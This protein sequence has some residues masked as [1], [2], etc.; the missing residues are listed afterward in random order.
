MFAEF[1]YDDGVM[2]AEQVALSVMAEQ[3]GTPFYCYST[4]RLRKNYRAFAEAF[5][6]QGATICFAVKACPNL[7]IIRTFGAM[8]AGADVVSGGELK[9]ALTAG[10]P[11][12]KI[13]FSGVGKSRADLELAIGARI[14]QINVE[15]VPELEAI[16][17][18]AAAQGVKMPVV[19]RVNPDVDPKTHAKIS[20][21]SK[22]T[23]FGIE[24]EQIPEA[25]AAARKFPNL[26]LTGFAVHIGSQLTELQPFRD[27]FT[28]VADLVR[29]WRAHGLALSRLDIGGGVGITYHDETPPAIA[30]YAAVVREILAPLDVALSMEPG[31]ALVGDAGILVSRVLFAKHGL[32]KRFLVVDA[33]MN[34][35]VR[36]AMYEAWHTILPVTQPAEETPHRAWDVVGPICETSDLFAADRV[37]PEIPAGQLVAFFGAGAYGASMSSTYNSRTL[38]P[39]VLVDGARFAV[40]R[41]PIPIE[42][43]IGWDLAPEWQAV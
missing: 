23:K 43:Q 25:I 29:H 12:E 24:Y 4:A 8:G 21:G 27:A 36:P 19:L 7:S 39:E 35:L 22:E 11:A 20:T 38:V 41:R 9:R 6:D 33:A 17:A 15:S 40:I 2:H 10:I 14:H 5:T 42:E 13:V 28:V 3:V 16:N 31:R 26:D 34:D 32:A 1:P 37:L 30:D 18:V